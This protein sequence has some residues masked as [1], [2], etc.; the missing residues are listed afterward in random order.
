MSKEVITV[1][2]QSDINAETVCDLLVELAQLDLTIPITVVLDHDL[3][4]FT[5][6]RGLGRAERAPNPYF[7][8]VN[9]RTLPGCAPR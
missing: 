3:A 4:S 2:N 9:L 6:N 7:F 8:L 5:Q 1:T